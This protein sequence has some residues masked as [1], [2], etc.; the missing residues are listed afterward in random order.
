[1][2]AILFSYLI[3]CRRVVPQNAFVLCGLSG[4][5]L[6]ELPA[7]PP[8]NFTTGAATP[9]AA[10]VGLRAAAV[11]ASSLQLQYSLAQDTGGAPVLHVLVQLDAGCTGTYGVTATVADGSGAARFAG[12]RALTTYCAAASSVSRAGAGAASDPPLAVV[13]AAAV[14]PSAPRGV[15]LVAAG[16]SSLSLAWDAPADLGGGDVRE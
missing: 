6:S 13:T 5:P 2:T 7:S 10:P 16:G 8:I 9:P 15:R 3:V 11:G 4:E 1:M 12:L 14:P